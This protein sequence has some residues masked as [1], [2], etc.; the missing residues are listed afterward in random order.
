MFIALMISLLCAPSSDLGFDP[1]VTLHPDGKSYVYELPNKDPA[2]V[3]SSKRW[4]RLTS[5]VIPA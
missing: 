1:H 3:G 5:V 4:R 2:K